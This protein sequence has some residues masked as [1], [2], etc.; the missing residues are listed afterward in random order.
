VALS[1]IAEGCASAPFGLT[2]DLPQHQLERRPIP[3]EHNF[4]FDERIHRKKKLSRLE[5]LSDETSNVF[6]SISAVVI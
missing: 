3:M 5:E 1:G 2:L 4:H 6:E